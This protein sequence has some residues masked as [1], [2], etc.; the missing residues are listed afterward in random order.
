MVGGPLQAAPCSGLAQAP[1]PTATVLPLCGLCSSPA[2]FLGTPP[3]EELMAAP[4]G[5]AAFWALS[6]AVSGSWVSVPTLFFFSSI[7]DIIYLLKMLSLPR[8][9]RRLW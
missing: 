2:S 5:L 6:L 1:L 4:T 8:A 3:L 7:N 9:L